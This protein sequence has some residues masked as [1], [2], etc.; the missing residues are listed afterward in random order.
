MAETAAQIKPPVLSKRLKALTLGMT[1]LAGVNTARA[2]EQQAPAVQPIKILEMPTTRQDTELPSPSFVDVLTRASENLEKE[3]QAKVE[4]QEAYIEGLS[5]NLDVVQSIRDIISKYVRLHGVPMNIAAAVC[6]VE[7][8][9][10]INKVSP[11]GAVGPFQLTSRAAKDVG[12]TIIVKGDKVIRD[13]RFIPEENIR[14]G[15]LL[16]GKLYEKF[17]DWGFALQAYSMGAK[18]VAELI[19]DLAHER[20]TTLA[21]NPT[22]KREMLTD[23]DFEVFAGYIKQNKL[24]VHE[25]LSHYWEGLD[26]ESRTYVY[27]V[28]AGVRK[29]EELG[30][31]KP[32]RVVLPPI[33]PSYHPKPPKGVVL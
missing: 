16:L 30:I 33:Q 19:Y 9:G 3:A 23:Q 5:P 13:D 6:A 25:L 2:L 20:G 18:A 8:G 29:L 1:A 15:T 7:N 27:K 14:G 10:G 24:S 32:E 4:K 21:V 28:A 22:V 17:N 31:V 12:V 26:E 11:K